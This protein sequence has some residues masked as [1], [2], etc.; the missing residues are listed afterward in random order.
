MIGDGFSPCWLKMKDYI[1]N[2]TQNPKIPGLLAVLFIW[3]CGGFYLGGEKKA[4]FEIFN[5]ILGPQV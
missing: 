4:S 5:L 3:E 2:K 1:K